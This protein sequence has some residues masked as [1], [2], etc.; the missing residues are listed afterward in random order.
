MFNFRLSGI[1][2][3]A[4]FLIS[5][6]LGIS[7][8][9]HIL[10]VVIRALGFGAAFFLLTLL[11]RH[12]IGKYIPDLLQV[13]SSRDGPPN[14]SPDSGRQVD[15]TLGDGEDLIPLNAALPPEESADDRVGNIAD[16]TK[17]AASRNSGGA[18]SDSAAM[19]G[20]PSGEDSPA[21]DS[22]GEDS[23][24]DSAS[25]QSALQ[26]MDQGPQSSY[27]QN[28]EGVSKDPIPSVQS[29]ADGFW[30]LGDIS[31][32]AESLPDLDS[33]AGSFLPPQDEEDP[34]ST[35][36]GLSSQPVRTAHSKK[37]RNVEED[38]NP[39]E[40]ASAIQTILKKD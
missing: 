18:S 15:I 1:A 29:P 27:T 13:A 11:I 31:D 10:I 22:L 19:P 30:G 24:E 40:L 6:A 25:F 26:G 28:R 16:L 5:L 20:S 21:G 14:T 2:A 32:D 8:R 38:F 34:P 3:A 12:I 9:G 4:A 35:G 33:L 37:G 17:P 23:L 36:Q 39:K 7:V